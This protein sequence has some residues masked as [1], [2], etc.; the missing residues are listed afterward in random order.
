MRSK[1]T[2]IS[3]ELV[4]NGDDEYHATLI[5]RHLESATH[6]IAIIAFAKISGFK[7]IRQTLTARAEK[8]LRATFV[9][10]IDFYQ[11]DPELLRALLS[12]RA[13]AK[14]AGGEIKV[15][16]GRTTNAPT[17]HPKAYWFKSRK[18]ETLIMGSA[19]MTSGGFAGNHELSI[20]L[21]GSN[22]NW[23]AW[24][25]C[26]IAERIENRDIIEATPKLIGN[27]ERQCDIFRAAMKAA[28]QRATR[29]M[30]APKGQVITLAD[31]LEEMR[32]DNGPNGFIEVAKRR[33]KNYGTAR[34][35]LAELTREPNL[36]RQ[37]FLTRYENL[38]RCWHSGGLQRGKNII[39]G[40]ATRFQKA[41]RALDADQ[42]KDA[43]H[44]FNLLKGHFD[45]IPSAGINA[46]TE[47]L[48]TR[49]PDR[50]PVMNR[51]S[52]AGLGLANITDYPRSLTK[53][54]VDG[55]CYA[56]F[57]ADAEALRA[58]L[59][60]RNLGELDIIFNFAY[61]KPVDTDEES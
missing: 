57:T 36:K 43:K 8:G 16:M 46:L 55:D 38:Y 7:L 34:Q 4:E 39:A 47:I 15:Y 1:T 14:K 26:W 59:G 44:L 50:Y 45:K 6:F 37:E 17:L 18:N 53:K 56:R 60:L 48:H 51:N 13:P 42:S 23:K 11:T 21:A 30:E 41:L 27:Y 35:L 3:H 32:A 9:I 52:V 54:T 33:R 24:L 58:R 25:D 61:C 40:K 10:G 22:A 5:E 2:P 20:M 49:D 12:L 19:N 28:K 29:S 31:L